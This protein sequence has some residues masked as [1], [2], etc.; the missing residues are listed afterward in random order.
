MRQP[1]TNIINKLYLNFLK[2]GGV[3]ETA[4]GRKNYETRD[5]RR[6]PGNAEGD[7]TYVTREKIAEDD[8]LSV[9]KG[10]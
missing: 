1:E 6:G 8:V 5:S 3:E 9:G 7:K 4:R 10:N 2:G